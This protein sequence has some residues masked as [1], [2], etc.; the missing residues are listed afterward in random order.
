VITLVLRL[1]PDPTS[2]LR[3]SVEQ[4]GREAETFRSEEE[5]IDSLY[6]A[7]E[8]RAGKDSGSMSNSAIRET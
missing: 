4:P 7:L 1:V 8:E 5:L 2:G 6:S 3:G